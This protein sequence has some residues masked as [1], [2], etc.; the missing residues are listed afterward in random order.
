MNDLTSG[1]FA[2]ADF[3]DATEISLA[4]YPIDSYSTTLKICRNLNQ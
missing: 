4:D 2:S 1:N 3:P